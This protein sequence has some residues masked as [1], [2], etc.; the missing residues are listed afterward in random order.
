MK[1][2]RYDDAR[3]GLVEGGT[4]YDITAVVE[5]ISA[6]MT[7]GEFDDP[8]VAAIPALRALPPAALKA[9]TAQPLAAVALLSPVR[10]PS[11][12]LAAPDNYK[13]HLE[14]MRKHPVAGGRQP[15]TLE[16]DGLFLKASSSIAGP[17]QG[18]ALRFPERRTDY[19]IELV[20]V[21]GSAGSVAGYCIGL[22]V[23]L[24]GTEE[25]SLRKSIDGYSVAGP[26]IVTA[27]ELRDPDAVDLILSLNGTIR[28]HTSASDML[29]NVAVLVDYAK[30]FYTLNPGDLIFT[31]TPSGV[32]QIQAGD[33]IE[34]SASGI[35]TMHVAVRAYRP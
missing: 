31:G 25:R 2:C 34:A 27:D 1:I 7:L 14:E 11:K 5:G 4:V 24:R 33:L 23:T 18:I 35:G 26:W 19:E 21:M 12:I 15:S 29:S 30:Q 9:G 32:G 17:A 13:A 16:K 3:A 20:A 10:R 22:D 28:Q 6:G 8:L